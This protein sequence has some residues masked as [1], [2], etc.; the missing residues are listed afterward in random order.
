[1]NMRFCLAGIAAIALLLLTTA[2]GQMDNPMESG[3]NM[4]TTT[5]SD[6]TSTTSD[7][8][9][10]GGTTAAPTVSQD[11][12]TAIALD[13]AGLTADAVE[14]LRVEYEVDDGIPRY[15]IEF[16]QG[17]TEYDYDIH[18]ETGQILSYDKND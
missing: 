7:G 10:T 17:A 1:M 6:I 3:D 13:H 2:C 12:A 15:E 9:V 14:G 11:N 16:R 8:V 5:T 18:A 4:A